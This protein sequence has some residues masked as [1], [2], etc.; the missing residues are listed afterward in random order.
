MIL[1]TA[2]ITEGISLGELRCAFPVWLDSCTH[3]GTSLLP[4]VSASSKSKENN[5]LVPVSLTPN[6]S[7]FSCVTRT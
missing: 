1:T 4:H 5:L 2:S 3:H 7:F 6:L